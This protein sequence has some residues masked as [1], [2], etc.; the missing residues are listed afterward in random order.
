MVMYCPF[1]L[2]KLAFSIGNP[3]API[4]LRLATER[5]LGA[6]FPFRQLGFHV[7]IR[8]R[9]ATRDSEERFERNVFPDQR[10]GW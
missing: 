4:R 5:I 6:E 8:S 7:Y 1:R 9:I 3:L 10:L 2:G